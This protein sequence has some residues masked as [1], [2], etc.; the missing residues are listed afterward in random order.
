[1]VNA[2]RSGGFNLQMSETNTILSFVLNMFNRFIN[3]NEEIRLDQGFQV[4]FKIFSYNHVNWQKSR[5]KQNRTLGCEQGNKAMRI[6]GCV[7]IPNGFPGRE[8]VFKNKCLLTST[9]V[10]S[11]AN[12]YFQ[13]NKVN[14][15][16]ERLI[17]LLYKQ[18][19]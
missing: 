18:Y 19:F 15:S 8:L 3:S 10:C 11:Y 2:L 12:L 1:M 14:E 9:V 16:F 7:E 5:R 4:Y 17:P 6:A 13:N